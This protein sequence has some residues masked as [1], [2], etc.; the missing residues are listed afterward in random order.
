MITK[1]HLDKNCIY[2]HKYTKQPLQLF[3]IAST[4]FPIY[5]NTLSIDNI[6]DSQALEFICIQSPP[7]HSRFFMVIQIIL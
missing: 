6:M 4:H 3:M 7:I 2:F 1:L 5:K